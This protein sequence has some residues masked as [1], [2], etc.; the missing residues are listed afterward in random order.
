MACTWRLAA[1]WRD[2]ESESS[3][4]SV[5][6]WLSASKHDQSPDNDASS[7]IVTRCRCKLQILTKLSPSR[8]HSFLWLQF[9]VLNRWSKVSLIR[10]DIQLISETFYVKR[11]CNFV[12]IFRIESPVRDSFLFSLKPITSSETAACP[13]QDSCV[14]DSC[15]TPTLRTWDSRHYRD[16]K[17]RYSRQAHKL[18]PCQSLLLFQ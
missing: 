6:T 11:F 8:G 9:D 12:F 15:N 2:K 5:M 13:H 18:C 4:T 3:V 1:S 10:G 7:E 14:I 17:S 16:I